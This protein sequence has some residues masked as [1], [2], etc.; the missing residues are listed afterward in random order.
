[1]YEWLSVYPL[2]IMQYVFI[3]VFIYTTSEYDVVF[4]CQQMDA[5]P[6]MTPS[7]GGGEDG[8]ST[9]ALTQEAAQKM[10]QLERERESLKAEQHMYQMK[11][12]A[13]E[14]MMEAVKSEKQFMEVLA[15]LYMLFVITISKST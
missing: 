7:V 3:E 5:P 11:W 1:M 15:Q 10:Q 9:V 6:S 14:D 2:I 4:I 8:S 13:A 12:L